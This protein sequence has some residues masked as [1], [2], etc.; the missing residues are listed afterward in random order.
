[1]RCLHERSQINENRYL[2]ARTKKQSAQS[3]RNCNRR[4]AIST[5]P[6]TDSQQNRWIQQ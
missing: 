1:M 4:P 6:K 3:M 5:T 2:K